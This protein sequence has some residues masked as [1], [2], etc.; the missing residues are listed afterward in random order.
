LIIFS[1]AATPSSVVNLSIPVIH[2]LES[3]CFM[4]QAVFCQVRGS[5]A[6]KQEVR[7]WPCDR[8]LRRL[9]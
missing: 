4:T 5:Y 6:G 3:F 9:H 8:C 1:G 2:S 7:K